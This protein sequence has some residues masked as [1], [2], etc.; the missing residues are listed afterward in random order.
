MI[1][2]NECAGR[3]N[4]ERQLKPSAT[5]EESAKIKCEGDNGDRKLSVDDSTSEYKREES[6]DNDEDE[7]G[8][9][10][11]AFPILLHEIVCDP[12]TDHCIRWLPNGN[13]FIISDKK[14]FAKEVLPKL[15]GHAKFTSFTRRLK[16]WGFT[17]I[18]SGPQIGA[19]QNKDFVKEDPERVKNIKYMHPKPLSMTA[20]Q[21]N[22]AKLQAA[23]AL[24]TTRTLGPEAFL[25]SPGGAFCAQPKTPDFAM[26][27]SLMAQ[28]QM[29]MQMPRQGANPTMGAFMRL[30]MNGGNGFPPNANNLASMCNNNNR[31]MAMQLAMLQ[32]MQNQHQRQQQLTQEANSVVA[33]TASSGSDSVNT[34]ESFGERLVRTN[35]SLAA[36]LIEA[37]N[38]NMNAYQGMQPSNPSAN[39]MMALLGG[40]NANPMQQNMNPAFFQQMGTQGMSSQGGDQQNFA[41]MMLARLQQEQQQQLQQQQNDFVKNFMSGQV[42]SLSQAPGNDNSPSDSASSSFVTP[43]NSAPNLSSEVPS[44]GGIPNSSSGGTWLSN[45]LTRNNNTGKPTQE[46]NT[47]SLMNQNV[48]SGDH[49]ND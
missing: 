4:E 30:A 45:L 40:Q 33:A 11:I 34:G 6:N 39:N 7:E 49:R 13:L 8:N 3:Q 5:E 1:T 27:Q 41:A 22:N 48:G 35:P 15:N 47:T 37:Q 42:N 18:A 25:G 38:I 9:N 10:K 14:K 28:Q 2:P 46:G 43:F 23:K 17:R 24:N 20:I 16:R 12:S 31:S 36:Q 26:L 29:G 44:S 19:Y 21:R 32:Q